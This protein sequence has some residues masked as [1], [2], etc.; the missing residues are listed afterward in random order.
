LTI[1]LPRKTDL[2]SAIQGIYQIRDPIGRLYVGQAR[3]IKRR[4]NNHANGL[5]KG[6]HPNYRLQSGFYDFEGQG[7]R[8]SVLARVADAADLD[9]EENHYLILLKPYY[10]LNERVRVDFANQRTREKI[11]WAAS[12]DFTRE[13]QTEIVDYWR[14]AGVTG[15]DRARSF[16]LLELLRRVAL[17]EPSEALTQRLEKVGENYLLARWDVVLS[18]RIYWHWFTYCD[19]MCRYYDLPRPSLH[20]FFISND[21][22]IAA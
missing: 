8:F 16:Q 15:L 20:E 2:S 11:D 6:R 10:N 22:R 12:A 5:V 9:A 14:R 1:K 21:A 18:E 19:E 4:W 7:F 3:D 13:M 17:F